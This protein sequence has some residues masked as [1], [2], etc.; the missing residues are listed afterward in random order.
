MTRPLDAH[1]ARQA[2]PTRERNEE[3]R[4]LHGAGWSYRRLGFVHSVSPQRIAQ[5]VKHP[6]PAA[7]DCAAE[8]AMLERDAEIRRLRGEG[9]GLVEL[10]SRF[11]LSRSRID[12]ITRGTR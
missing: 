8:R 4:R 3:I 2:E 7:R 1:N 6:K 11:G 5:I 10:A 12:Q 9:W